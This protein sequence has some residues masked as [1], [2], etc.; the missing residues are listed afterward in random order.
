VCAR[1]EESNHR[2]DRFVGS[3][4]AKM[5]VERG[6]RVVLFDIS[7]NYEAVEPI[8]NNVSVVRGDRANWSEV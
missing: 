1:S 5:L 2:W 4:L 3:E 6:E 8:K 7:P